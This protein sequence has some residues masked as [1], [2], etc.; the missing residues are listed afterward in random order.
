MAIAM[1]P[2]LFTGICIGF[3]PHQY[4]VQEDVSEVNVTIKLKLGSLVGT[5]VAV[6]I[7]SIDGSATCMSSVTIK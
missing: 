1:L 6:N 4:T 2:F 7:S 5:N 3:D